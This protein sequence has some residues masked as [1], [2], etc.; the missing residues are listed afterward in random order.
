MGLK[1]FFNSLIPKNNN[2]S[3][4]VLFNTLT[5]AIN[6][7]NR[8]VRA[9]I[10]HQKYVN[11]NCCKRELCDLMV[12]LLYKNYLRF[13][14]VQCKYRKNNYNGLDCFRVNCGQHY[15][16]VKKPVISVCRAILKS[17]I[18]SSS[19]YNTI[20][21][22]SVFYKDNKGFYDFDLASAD[23]VLCSKKNNCQMPIGSYSNASHSYKSL[24]Y[25]YK[26]KLIDY[27]SHKNI[28]EIEKY[29]YF[30]EAIEY[31]EVNKYEDFLRLI[32]SFDL[33]SC[34]F[35]FIKKLKIDGSPMDISNE[36]S[37]IIKHLLVIGELND[38]VIK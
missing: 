2:I 21:T 10:M 30:G 36:N 38:E 32:N 14:F 11:A 28:D 19:K 23:S 27:D 35:E 26:N 18:L 7:L 4:V 15:I 13:S 12:V 8:G 37:L 22:Y 29:P 25:N 9:C 17:N 20:T 6:G 24:N 3:E 1:Q 33:N 34:D 16:L 5:K 31:E